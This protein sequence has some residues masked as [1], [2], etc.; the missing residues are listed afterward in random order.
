VLQPPRELPPERWRHVPRARPSP[1]QKRLSPS[2]LNSNAT[3]PGSSDAH[4]HTTEAACR[5]ACCAQTLRIGAGARREQ[6]PDNHYG[7]HLRAEPG[8][9]EGRGRRKPILKG[10][11]RKATLRRAR[12]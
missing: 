8:V 12:A 2:S 1:S 9:G 6:L 7:N 10:R 5:A 11:Q 4:K 3:S